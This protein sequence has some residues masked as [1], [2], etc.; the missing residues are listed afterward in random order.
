MASFEAFL[1][2]YRGGQKFSDTARVF[3]L[4]PIVNKSCKIQCFGNKMHQIV[5]NMILTQGLGQLSQSASF[6][7]EMGLKSEKSV[8][9]CPLC[10]SMGAEVHR[11][12]TF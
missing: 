4:N 2:D 1:E 11:L 8:N 7:L 10:I 6:S 3:P 9:L 5:R 12:F